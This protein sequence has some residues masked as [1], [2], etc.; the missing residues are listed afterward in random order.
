MNT[1][2]NVPSPSQLQATAPERV[3][4]AFLAALRRRSFVEARDLFDDPFV[5]TDHALGLEFTDKQRLIEFLNKTY[6][7]FPDTARADETILHNEAY[8]ISGWTLTATQL[9]PFYGGRMRQIA[10]RVQGISV[11]LI[12]NGKISRWSEYYDQL[13]SRRSGLAG[14]FAEWDEL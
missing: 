1:T 7:F 5:Y 10:I 12:N 8:I 6:E 4:R 9:E 2:S 11:V 3:L 14:W 13:T